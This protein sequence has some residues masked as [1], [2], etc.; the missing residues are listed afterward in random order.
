MPHQVVPVRTYVA[1]FAA[2]LALTAIT[3]AVAFRDLEPLHNLMAL[4]IAA[5]KAALVVLYF[6]HAKGSPRMTKLVIAAALAW[7]VLLFA[8]TLGDYLSRDWLGVPGK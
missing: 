1:I 7:L 6:M 8:L 2:L 4:G 3:T 5:I